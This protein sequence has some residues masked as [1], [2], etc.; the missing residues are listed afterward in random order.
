MKY[1]D[2]LNG[3]EVD[4]DSWPLIPPYMEIEGKDKSEVESIENLLE[5]D[6]EKITYL[7]CSD[8]Y[9]TIYGIDSSKIKK[10]KF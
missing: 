6:K 1:E 4:I 3:V 10:L 2:L 5:V 8:I 7:N 9:K